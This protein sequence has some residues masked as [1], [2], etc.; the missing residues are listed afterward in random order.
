MSRLRHTGVEF[1]RVANAGD[2][3]RVAVLLG[4]DSAEREVSLM[5]GKAVHEALVA[6]GIEAAPF[7]P[8]ERALG[9]L[10]T[11][12]F[13]RAFIAL[14]GP[15]GEDG[16]LQGALEW[17]GLPYT[18]SGVIGSAVGMDKLRTKRLAQAA[19]VATPPWM[20]LTGAA[21]FE[22]AIAELG[23]PLA[24]K[25]ATQG[26]SV[27]MSRVTAAVRAARRLARRLGARPGGHRGTLDHRRRVHRLRPAGRSAAGDPHRDAAD[28][29]RLPG[30]VL[31]RRHALPDSLRPREVRRG[32][33]A[34]GGA[35]DLRRDRRLGLG[36]RRIS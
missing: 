4:G 23:L 34:A 25:P 7:D 12:G 32:G 11:D 14:H 20:E 15:G 6:R 18:G 8:A 19:G 30:E 33:H 3:G 5:T 24:V 17:L 16:A 27:G 29:L 26:S 36:P 35:R 2:F 31:R 22:R 9:E 21:D 10:V 13:D 1:R 28:V